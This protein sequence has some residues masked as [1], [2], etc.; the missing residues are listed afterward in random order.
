MSPKR[1]FDPSIEEVAHVGL[2]NALDEFERAIIGKP[3]AYKFSVYIYL[4]QE[5]N[6]IANQIIE[7]IA[8]SRGGKL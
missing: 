3:H 7:E 1:P 4:A 2:R 5:I 6:E 8:D